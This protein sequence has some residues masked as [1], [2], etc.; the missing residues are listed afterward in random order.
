MKDKIYYVL[1][2]ISICHSSSMKEPLFSVDHV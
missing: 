2:R 1:L